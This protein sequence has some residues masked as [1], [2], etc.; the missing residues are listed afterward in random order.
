MMYFYIICWCLLFQQDR[1]NDLS[2]M[3]F[4]C[5]RVW[6]ILFH[7]YM[8][9]S[10]QQRLLS[11]KNSQLSTIYHPAYSILKLIWTCLMCIVLLWFSSPSLQYIEIDMDMF[12]VHCSVV[13]SITQLTVY[14]NWYGHVW[15]ALFC[16]GFHH[17]AYSILKLIW[18][19]LMCIVLLWFLSPS[20]QYI[21]IDMDMFDV[22]CSVVVS[23]TQLTVYWNWYGHVWCALFCCGFYHP[24]Y[25]ILRLIWTCLMCIVLLWFLSPSLQY[26]EIDMDMFD[27]HCSVVVS[28]TQLTVYWNWYGHVWCAL[29]CCGFYHP[30]YSILKLIWTCF[31]MH[32]SVVIFI[33]SSWGNHPFTHVLNINLLRLWESYGRFNNSFNVSHSFGCLFLREIAVQD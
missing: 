28:I 24:A 16:C 11:S 17:P 5:G 2:L 20:L 1:H 30:A 8:N 21:E 10:K 22:H 4:P 6:T 31:D 27:V 23:I 13:V 33:M 9:I 29:F 25:S 14:W 18:T 12:D 7:I 19:C 26:I 15:C 32:C 3:N